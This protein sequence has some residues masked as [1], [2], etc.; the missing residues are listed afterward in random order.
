[1]KG[2][3]LAAGRGSRLQPYSQGKP[4]AL[5]KLLGLTLIERA[6]YTLKRA[7]IKDIIIVI[8]YKGE[9]VKEFLG[10]ASTLGVKLTYVWNDEWHKDNGVS[11]Y[12]VKE[13]L[14][15]GESFILLMVDHVVDPK[16]ISSL[17]K[18]DTHKNIICVD[19][20][21]NKDER[22]IQES[23]KVLAKGS[24]V[25][26]IGK[27]LKEFNYLDCGVFKL[28][29]NVF[30]K[31]ESLV[32]NGKDRL[33]ELIQELAHN[34][35]LTIYDVNGR[36]W[37]DIDTEE[38]VKIIERELLQSLIKPTDGFISRKLNRKISIWITKLLVKTSILPSHLSI[39]SFIVAVLSGVAF[40][41]GTWVYS[42]L[43]GI[44]A[45]LS[46]IIDSCDGELARLKFRDTPFGA[47]YDSI[48]DRYADGFILLGMVIGLL[49]I[50]VHNPIWVIIITCAALIGL[51]LSMLCK[52][53]Y[54][55]LTGAELKS[56]IASRDIR[57]FIIFIFG[58]LNLNFY[59]ILLIAILTHLNVLYY[60]IKVRRVFNMG[61][62][63]EV[64]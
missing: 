54:Y 56:G 31:L 50:G 10:D 62:V 12:K 18:L 29:Y 7:G 61:T 26:R 3:I 15:P 52:D 47:F 14:S 5:V 48:L 60:F 21:E 23:T 16:I 25:L 64:V 42:I 46:S 30:E 44:F 22:K 8:G 9:R 37:Y 13:Y 32:K 17:K 63:R 41:M 35:E 55:R 39:L 20:C 2:V 33:A 6:I 57:L 51:P 40:S 53:R 24:R 1:M 28:N 27:R 59:A 45:Q 36:L 4:K 34:D 19:K 58:L 11:L 43:G 38:D 49:K